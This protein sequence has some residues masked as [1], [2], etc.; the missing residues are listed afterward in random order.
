MHDPAASYRR[1]VPGLEDPREEDGT[2]MTQPTTE[3]TVA[4]AGAIEM[5]HVDLAAI[6]TEVLG[7]ELRPEPVCA[8]LRADPARFGKL[9]KEITRRLPHALVLVIDQAE[10]IFTLA[11]DPRDA[12][13]GRLAVE[14]LRKA[15]AESGNFK[16]IVSLR[17]E[18]YGRFIDGLRTGVRDV[19]GVREYLLTDFGPGSLV[20]AIRRPTCTEPIPGATEV[21]FEKYGFRYADGVAERIAVRVL[22]HNTRSQDSVLPL[23]QVICS[24][25]YEIV[26]HRDGQG[27][28]AR[29]LRCHRQC[30]GRNAAARRP[31]RRGAGPRVPRRPP[32][33]QAADDPALPP[34]VGRRPDHRADPA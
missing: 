2:A 20:E 24:Q 1:P 5:A 22:T 4:G 7:C 16:I 34:P 31:A 19:V 12:E 13:N 29:G 17:T 21:P 9:L 6:A 15:M 18:Y 27:D 3:A 32:P 10:E 23:V 11:R 14:L 33:V 26:R 28:P 30:P 25:L 8:V